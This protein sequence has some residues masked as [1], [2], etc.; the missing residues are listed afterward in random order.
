V[1]RYTAGEVRKRLSLY[2]SE[3]GRKSN[4]RTTLPVGTYIPEFLT[5]QGAL[6]ESLDKRDLFT[7]HTHDSECIAHFGIESQ[8][9]RVSSFA[10]E[11][12]GTIDPTARADTPSTH[13]LTGKMWRLFSWLAL[14]AIIL[15]AVVEVGLRHRDVVSPTVVDAF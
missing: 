11:E 14:A 10:I 15:V 8:E 13:V 3:E 12:A 1:V 9:Q 4:I 5:V 2:Y 6:I 7:T